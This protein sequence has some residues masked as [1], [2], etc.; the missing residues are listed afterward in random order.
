MK[1]IMPRRHRAE[2]TI[3]TIRISLPTLHVLDQLTQ[4]ESK[5]RN[6]II[7]KAIHEHATPSIM[8]ALGA[9]HP[10]TTSGTDFAWSSCFRNELK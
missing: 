5:S 8:L 4:L 6:R 2:S 7:I 9:A 1:R 3:I 10:P